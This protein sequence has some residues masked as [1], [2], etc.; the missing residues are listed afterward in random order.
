M[1]TAGIGFAINQT[2]FK[3]D[4]R[5]HRILRAVVYFMITIFI[6]GV[7]GTVDTLSSPEKAMYEQILEPLTYG[8]IIAFVA[9]VF[10]LL[11]ALGGDKV[12]NAVKNRITGSPAQ[13]QAG[14]QAAQQAQ[15]QAA[16]PPNPAIITDLTNR[17]GRFINH[18][19]QPPNGAV[20]LS[21]VLSNQFRQ[22]VELIITPNPLPQPLSIYALHTA[23]GANYSA[24]VA[25]ANDFMANE[26]SQSLAILQNIRVE[27]E[28]IYTLATQSGQ[29]NNV[30]EGVRQQ[31]EQAVTQF[32][33]AETQLTSLAGF[34]GAL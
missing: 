16:A 9:G 17:M 15:Q 20:V 1:L 19:I 13:Q 12:A 18:V 30:A 14:Q 33:V 23:A 5:M 2:S 28:Q 6:F 8:A 31:Y 7:I 25:R 29:Y 27:M 32:L 21:N 24:V 11:M 34:I 4:S 10:N 22:D 3:G 26:L